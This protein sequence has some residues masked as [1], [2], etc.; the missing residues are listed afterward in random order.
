MSVRCMRQARDLELHQIMAIGECRVSGDAVYIVSGNYSTFVP[1][2]S[3][4]LSL[5]CF[6]LCRQVRVEIVKLSQVKRA[7]VNDPSR[8]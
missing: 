6:D 1:R 7:E 3:F 4:L 2:I 8:R 5:S